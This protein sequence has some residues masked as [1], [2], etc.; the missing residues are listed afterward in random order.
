V[1][2]DDRRVLLIIL[3]AVE[4]KTIPTDPR[5]VDL[6]DPHHLVGF[7]FRLAVQMAS[8]TCDVSAE[9]R[10]RLR[11]LHYFPVPIPD[12]ARVI[13]SVQRTGFAAGLLMAD[14]AGFVD[15][16]L[17]QEKLV[18]LRGRN[19]RVTTVAR[20]RLNVRIDDGT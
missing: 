18:V 6:D 14:V 12:V 1:D 3:M 9:E 4:A 5:I 2:E 7:P 15:R 8:G 13:S 19:L 20:V 11:A 16:I 17:Q 10:K